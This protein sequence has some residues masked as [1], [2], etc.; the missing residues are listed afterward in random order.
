LEVILDYALVHLHHSGAGHRV[1][2]E[3][4]GWA[5]INVA[6]SYSTSQCREKPGESMNWMP[7]EVDRLRLYQ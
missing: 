5:P 7:E 1:A 6:K 4:G 3:E 2:L